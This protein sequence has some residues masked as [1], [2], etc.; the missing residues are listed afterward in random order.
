MRNRGLI[1]VMVFAVAILFAGSV[2]AAPIVVESETDTLGATIITWEASFEDLDYTLGNPIV[3][4]VNWIVVEGSATYDS[5]VLRSY[6]PK[7]KIDPAIGTDPVVAGNGDTSV[8][9]EFLFSDLHYDEDYLV[10][11]GNGHFKFFLMVD[12]DGD[13]TPET[14][15]GF[16]VN[17]H[18]ED[19]Q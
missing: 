11:I 1:A 2:S 3:L 18:V 8:T 12:E 9:F 19:P 14:R 6:T 16:G 5:F 13:G 17:I 7:T 4:T 15:A 10:D